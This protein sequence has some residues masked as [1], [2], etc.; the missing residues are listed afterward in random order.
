MFSLGETPYPTVDNKH[1]LLERLTKGERMTRPAHCPDEVFQILSKC[2][3]FDPL[4][5][6]TFE[7]LTDWFETRLGKW[8]TTYHAILR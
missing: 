2:W 8:P 3:N 1:E 4:E 6:P 5:R 7:K